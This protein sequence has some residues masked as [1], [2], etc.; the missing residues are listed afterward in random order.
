[1]S[2]III[3]KL[4]LLIFEHLVATML[5][6]NKKEAIETLA[7]R[8]PYLLKMLTNLNDFYLELK[9]DFQTWIPL[10]S[11]ILPSDTCKIYKRDCALRMDT[12]LVDFNDRSW[13]RG[14]I[15]FLFN[16]EN[17]RVGQH[18]IV[19]DNKKKVKYFFYRKFINSLV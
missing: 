11:K 4:C 13:E 16:P 15:S 10:L 14:D 2:V 19:M 7:N 1:M 5:F 18:F 12:T 9:W 3:I 8:K 17:E 6:L